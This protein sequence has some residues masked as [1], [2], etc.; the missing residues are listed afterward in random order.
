MTLD[1]QIAEL[2]REIALRKNVYPKWVAAG[3]MRQAEMDHHMGAMTAA[4]HTAMAVKRLRATM[5]DHRLTDL[6][7]IVPD[8]VAVCSCNWR[9]EKRTESS[10]INAW[11][12]HVFERSK[13]AEDPSKRG[14][15]E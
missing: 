1:Q 11:L 15:R 12:D 4:L 2:K 14:E 9:S 7:T 3:K 5:H 6:V 13:A 10:A 8:K